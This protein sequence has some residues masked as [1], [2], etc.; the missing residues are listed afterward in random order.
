[1]AT[2]KDSCGCEHSVLESET[3]STKDGL[4]R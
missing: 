1:L 3:S 2:V 4:K